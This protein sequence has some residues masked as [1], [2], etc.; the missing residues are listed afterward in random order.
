M[1]LIK[2]IGADPSLTRGR[3]TLART[4]ENQR[5]NYLSLAALKIKRGNRSKS[6]GIFR[7][8]LY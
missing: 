5:L 4:A 7:D 6:L 2:E 3:L 1:L 8:W